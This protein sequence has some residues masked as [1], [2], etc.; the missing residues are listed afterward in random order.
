M[1]SWQQI[2]EEDFIDFI[3]FL[4]HIFMRYDHILSTEELRVYLQD[5]KW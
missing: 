1:K 4:D 2:I 5:G 3:D